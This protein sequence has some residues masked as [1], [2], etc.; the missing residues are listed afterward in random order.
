MNDFIKDLSQRLSEKGY[1]VFAPDLYKGKIAES[2]EEAEKCINSMEE[3]E[4][5]HILAE[6]VDYLLNITNRSIRVIGF[7]M[8]AGWATW[9]ANNKPESIEK[10][11]LFYGTG[12]IDFSKT[13]A[14][15]LCHFAE[16][17]PY[18]DPMYI[19]QFKE[20]LKKA[21]IQATHYH[22]QGTYH[23][24]FETNQVDYYNKQASELA[25]KRTLK[26]LND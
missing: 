24:F 17:D 8:G 15:F 26:F 4:T 20:A 23:W 6:S 3:D 22:Y 16:N 12:E 19:D 10:V 1:L 25:W 5:K 14:S 18:E 13:H 9:I 21:N 11:V 7:S 2:I